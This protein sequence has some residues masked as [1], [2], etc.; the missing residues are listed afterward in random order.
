MKKS[1]LLLL[2]L[3]IFAVAVAPASAKATR[4][5]VTGAFIPMEFIEVLEPLWFDEGG[6]AHVTTRLGGP[7]EMSGD[8]INI[9]GRTVIDFRF[10]VNTTTVDGVS[11]G[12][13]RVY[14]GDELIFEGQIQGP[15]K[16]A[17]ATGH[18]SAMG[19]GS[20]AGSRLVFE[21]TERV[22]PATGCGTEL[23]DFSG[24]LIEHS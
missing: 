10:V 9:V 20:Y 7:F 22:N 17:V 16:C 4:T 21:Y 6:N 12:P 18:G 11:G 23:Y 8:G 5:A 14:D 13:F 1:I 19:K 2:L 24:I 3:I 15:M